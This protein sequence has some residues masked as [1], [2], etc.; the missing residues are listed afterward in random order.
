[1][2]RAPCHDPLG[3]EIEAEYALLGDGATAAV[4]VAAASGLSLLAEDER[5]P[6]RA[7]TAGTG[8]LVVGRRARPGR[9]R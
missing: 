7:T 4:D 9:R 5:D 6:W 1:M 2:R 3:R 8:E